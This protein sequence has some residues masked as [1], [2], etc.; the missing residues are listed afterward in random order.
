[1]LLLLA[2][3]LLLAPVTASAHVFPEN[4]V[5]GVS[6]Y[7]SGQ[8]VETLPLSQQTATGCVSCPAETVSGRALWLSKDPIGEKGGMNLYGYCE[9]DPINASDS[10]GLDGSPAPWQQL[11][12]PVGP[13]NGANLGEESWFEQNVP[14]F[15]ANWKS[16][17]TNAINS[18]IISDCAMGQQDQTVGPLYDPNDSDQL[19]IPNGNAFNSYIY[20]NYLLGKVLVEAADTAVSWRGCNFNWTAKLNIKSKVGFKPD[21]TAGW[22]QKHIQYPLWGKLIPILPPRV[23]T[24]ASWT[25]QGGG[26]AS[27]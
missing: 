4:R 6:E 26:N 24:R 10:T 16:W 18:K 21:A 17:A 15:L 11:T 9:D 12:P 1:M 27:Q 13:S 23:I 8:N 22:F 25:I 14:G 2:A 5:R 19:P 3:G 20:A 7:P